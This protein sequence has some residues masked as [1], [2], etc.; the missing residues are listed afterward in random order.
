[1]VAEILELSDMIVPLEVSPLFPTIEKHMMEELVQVSYNIPETHID[2]VFAELWG[3]ALHQAD[4]PGYSQ[5]QDHNLAWI[6]SGHNH[7]LSLRWFH[8]G[9]AGECKLLQEKLLLACLSWEYWKV[10][11]YSQIQRSQNLLKIT[12]GAGNVL[13]WWYTFTEF[14]TR[15]KIYNFQ[16]SLLKTYA[17]SQCVRS[18]V[19]KVAPV[20]QQD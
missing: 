19:R 6:M 3:L 17:K 10:T 8:Q 14:V 4:A 16:S 18:F 7:Q 2:V 5:Q 20:E 13:V 12:F 11:F 1:M 15:P 9:H